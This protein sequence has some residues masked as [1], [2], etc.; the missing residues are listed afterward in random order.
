[1]PE[2]QESTVS[3]KTKRNVKGQPPGHSP[4]R[5]SAASS[6]GPRNIVIGSIAVVLLALGGWALLHKGDDSQSSDLAS[7]QRGSALASEN[8]P[9]LG[10][11]SAK[12][13]IVEF[14][15][16]AC[17]TCAE[18]F[19]I[20]K[21][22]IADNP[23]RIRLSV[24]HVAFHDGSEH[25]VRVLEASRKQD[26]YWQTMEALLA[27]QHRWAPNHVAQPDL[28]I[29]S[30]AGVGLNIDQLL[31]DIN[32]PDVTQRIEQDRN[33]AML[34]KVTATPEYFVNGRPMPSFG[35]QQLRTLISDALA[36][37]Y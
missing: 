9:T 12:V 14:L 26:K 23:G 37:A 32:A 21:Q 31:A 28:I 24:R 5:A 2:Q 6:R 1:V 13:H 7:T 35:E 19:P 25:A 29:S 18:F 20:A 16:P 36:D 30:I 8:A 22:Y 34:L 10:D 33:D 27:S 4:Q 17:E 11:A 15:D 3:R